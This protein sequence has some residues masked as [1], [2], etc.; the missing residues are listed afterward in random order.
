MKKVSFFMIALVFFLSSC[1]TQHL[2]PTYADSGG[3]YSKKHVPHH[4]QH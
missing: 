4:L 1:E 2:C 3:H